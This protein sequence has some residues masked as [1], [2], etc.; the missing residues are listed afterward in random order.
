MYSY[1]GRVTSVSIHL[2]FTSHLCLVKDKWILAKGTRDKL[3]N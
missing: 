3:K 1:G 2:G